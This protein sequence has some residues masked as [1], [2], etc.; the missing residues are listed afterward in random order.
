MKFGYIVR[1]L[2]FLGILTQ[3][4]FYSSCR[5]DE[6]PGYNQAINPIWD[7]NYNVGY[8]GS[9]MPILNGEMVFFSSFKELSPDLSSND[10]LIAL[11][12]LNGKLI[13]EWSDFLTDKY[14]HMPAKRL[15]YI[16]SDILAFAVGSQNFAINLSN[17][18]TLWKNR[19]QPSLGDVRGDKSQIYRIDVYEPQDIGIHCEQLMRA[20]IQSGEWEMIFEV[21]GGDSLRQGLTVPTFFKHPNGDETMIMANSVVDNTLNETKGYVTPYLINYNKTRNEMIYEVVLD[22]PGLYSRVDWF[23]I[24]EGDLVYLLVETLMV[25]HNINTGERVWEK[26]FTGDFLF[27]GAII[28]DGRIYA[29][30]DGYDPTLYCIDALTG[31]IIWQTL[32]SG[33]S[34]PLEYHKGII[35]FI[36]GSDGLFYVV[37]ATTGQIIYKIKAPSAFEDSNDF[38]TATGCKVDTI[39]EKVYLSSQTTAYCYPTATL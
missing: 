3:L 22:N 1:V 23:P 34:S 28:R 36:G 11:N 30:R 2:L 24:I 8:S 7:Y 6:L 14:A 13:W 37:N 9:I 25:C 39:E 38:F 5:E 32:S 10:K 35:Y 16:F 4:L 31:S 20:N 12:K 26:R 21:K 19:T 27:S 15:K 18:E 29:N 17:G 33:T